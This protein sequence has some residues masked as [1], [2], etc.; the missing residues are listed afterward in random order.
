MVCFLSA[1]VCAVDDEWLP[2]Q[3]DDFDFDLPESQIA[4]MPHPTRDGS[5][6]LRVLSDGSLED[7]IF[8]DL[9]RFFKKGDVLV[10]NNSRVLPAALKGR[11]IRG[12]AEAQVSLNLHKRISDNE[13]LAFAKPA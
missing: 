11:R 12:D 7:H 6:L 8:K 10:F 2:L 9:P 4:L 5:K 1:P 3:L 13:W